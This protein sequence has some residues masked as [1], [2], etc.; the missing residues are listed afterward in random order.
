MIGRALEPRVACLLLALV[1]AGAL[2]A[3]LAMEYLAHLPPCHLCVWQ[4][5][6][7]LALVVLG[8]LGWR[9]AAR[10]ILALAALILLGEA[11]L[12]FYHVGVE[13]G[14][15]A[16]PASCA[17]GAEATSIEDLKRLLVEAPPACD[18]VSV[19]FLGLSLA[20][21]NVVTA[22][23]LAAYATVAARGQIGGAVRRAA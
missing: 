19:T 8:L 1:S 16:L 12:A 20:S 22:L 7:Y 15:W 3:T 4:R 9:T 17:A 18:Q 5:W 10:P 13:Q 23:V 14:W 21:W 2:L 6:P 11:G